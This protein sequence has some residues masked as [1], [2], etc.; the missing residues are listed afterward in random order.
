MRKYIMTKRK[1]L[2]D[3]NDKDCTL[4]SGTDTCDR[5]QSAASDLAS[6]LSSVWPFYTIQRLSTSLEHRSC[7]Y[8]APC[9]SLAAPP[10]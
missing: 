2:A 9:Q 6:L 1:R 3:I 4:G 10:T 7:R 8:N 5:G